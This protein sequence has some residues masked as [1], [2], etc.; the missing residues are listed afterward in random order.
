MGKGSDRRSRSRYCSAEEFDTRW[1]NIFGKTATDISSQDLATPKDK[2]NGNYGKSLYGKSPKVE[3]K[4]QPSIFRQ[5]KI[6]PPK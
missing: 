1:N 6:F 2:P 3:K 5:K 4:E